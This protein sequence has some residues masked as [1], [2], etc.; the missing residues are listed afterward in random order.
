MSEVLISSQRSAPLI[1]V[2]WIGRN[3][4][5]IWAQ[6]V[7]HVILTAVPV[8]IGLI[9]ALPLS[10]V[11]VYWPRT[12][13]PMIGISGV[14][15]T[16]PSLALFVLMIPFTGLSSLTAIIPLSIYTQLILIRNTTDGL[17]GV[18]RD[19]REAAAAMGYT[20]VRQIVTVQGPIALPVIFTGIR[21][22][23][24]TT[25]GLVT[26][27]ALVG[28]GGLGQ[29]F[30]DGFMRQFATPLLVGLVLVILLAVIVDV[31]LLLIQRW[32]T[33]WTRKARV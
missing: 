10:L 18:D 33:P 16:I 28:Q 12:Y 22:A 9:I 23:S 19:V 29:L 13:N 11:A 3:T 15:F 6:F 30:T 24:I 26:V 21:I 1:D 14:L 2:G 5:M 25:I 32:L 31:G 17:R 4:D 20:R 27:S 7:E 8:A